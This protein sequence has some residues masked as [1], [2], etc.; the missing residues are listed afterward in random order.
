MPNN[1]N[2]CHLPLG[3]SSS[4]VIYI[5][6]II[7]LNYI[8]IC[9]IYNNIYIVIN[10]AIYIL[11]YTVYSIITTILI[12]I[13]I[14]VSIIIGSRLE[15]PWSIQEPPVLRCWT[16]MGGGGGE[17]SNNVRFAKRS[18]RGWYVEDVFWSMLACMNW[19]VKPT[20]A[21][22]WKCPLWMWSSKHAKSKMHGPSHENW[23]VL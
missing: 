12:I 8:Y 22:K 19:S 21:L 20:E 13:I 1:T 7:R 15:V 14:I 4:Y 17:V 2:I 3:R 10:I 5:Y 6:I 16:Q 11:L 9:I 23:T 18:E